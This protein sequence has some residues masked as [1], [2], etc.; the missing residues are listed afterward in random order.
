MFQIPLTATTLDEEEVEAATRVLRSKWLTMG[1]EVATFEREFAEAIGTRHAVAVANGTLALEI[2]YRAVGI[3]PGDEV[4]IPAITFVACF[5]AARLLGARPVLVDVI[6]DLDWTLDPNDV[7][8]K[9]TPRTRALVTM[10]HGGFAPAMEELEAL[11]RARGIAV[12][13]DA[14][15]APLASCGGRAV[16]TFGD[17]ATWSFFGNKNLTTGEGGMITTDR[18]DVAEACRLMR[19][20]GITKTTWDRVRGHAF[21]YDVALVGT[22]ARLDEIRAAIGRVQ[23]RKLAGANSAR[24]LVAADLRAR[25]EHAAIPGLAIPYAKP[26]GTSAHHLFCVALPEG[27]DR[28]GVMGTLRQAGVQ[29]SIHYPALHEFSSTCAY[30][31]EAGGAEGLP[32][33][34]RLSP[35][36]LTL[37]LSPLQT[38]EENDHIVRCLG[39]ALNTR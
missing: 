28:E 18:D 12:V 23:L 13:E 1:E 2:A 35:R 39:A 30:F 4:L 14:C 6:S 9:V 8:R 33:A 31:A 36:I 26:R 29:T 5:N 38:R 24:A 22:N 34:E 21:A 16:G 32:R 17:A 27:T 25:L 20:H 15:H 7:E 37:P 3:G 10:P 11:A 19:S